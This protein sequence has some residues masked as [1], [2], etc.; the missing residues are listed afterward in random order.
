MNS[1]KFFRSL[2]FRI[3]NEGK[4]VFPRNKK[5]IEIENAVILFPPYVRFVNFECRH[6]KLSYIKKEFLWYLKGDKYDTS[7]CEYASMWKNFINN[8]GSINS[9]YGQY[10]FGNMNQFDNV[11]NELINDR[12]SRRASIIIL[13]PYHLLNKDMKEVPC[14]YSINFRIREDKL[15]MS[16]KM[17]SQDAILGG[18]SDWPIFSFIHEMA[19]NALK[20]KYNNLKLGDYCHFVDSLHIYE[21]HFEMAKG[22]STNSKY[23]EVDCP[24]ISSY[25]EVEILRNIHKINKE[26]IDSEFKFANWILS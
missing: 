12:D 9:N 23:E 10:I 26:N 21:K 20:L 11:I 15:N 4:I 2:Y 22:I 6:L 3:L 16:V 7:I 14:T 1:E 8:D 19:L 24:K 13:Q 17:R 25:K 18:G 5:C